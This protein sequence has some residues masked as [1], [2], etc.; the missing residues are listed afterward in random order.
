[1]NEFDGYI[2][3]NNKKHFSIEDIHQ[4]LIDSRE[5]NKRES[6]NKLLIKTLNFNSDT[7]LSDELIKKYLFEILE[8]EKYISNKFEDNNDLYEDFYNAVTKYI[9][10]LSYTESI[11]NI[12]KALATLGQSLTNIAKVTYEN[13][14]NEKVLDSLRKF[15]Q[16]LASIHYNFED[17]KLIDKN[18]EKL[19]KYRWVVSFELED[20]VFENL[21]SKTKTNE[22]VLQ[23]Y[24]KS[25]I[26]KLEKEIIDGLSFD[27]QLVKYFKES[28]KDYLNKAYLSC[29]TLLFAII[30][31]L[32][33][34]NFNCKPGVSGI[35]SLKKYLEKEEFYNG[36]VNYSTIK[37]LFEL[38][39]DTKNFTLEKEKFNRNMID[40]GWSKRNIKPYECLQLILI[41]NNLL[42]ILNNETSIMQET[43]K[44]NI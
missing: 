37:V 30:D 28:K 21:C 10:D 14:F 40:H 15:A 3:I 16:T 17:S 8:N 13:I 24:T 43:L 5:L 18:V 22:L 1:M 9:N 36:Y 23:F 19:I 12:T 4:Y 42:F 39:E 25:R 38:Y 44:Q 34:M 2:K 26:N 11:T 7:I 31:R 29:V 32:I 41:I 20:Y 35:A 6:L 27:K 33:S